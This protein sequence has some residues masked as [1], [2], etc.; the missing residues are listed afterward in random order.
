MI[1]ALILLAVC[2]AFG[3]FAGKTSNPMF[4]PRQAFN[5]FVPLFGAGFGAVVGLVYGLILV[6]FTAGLFH[7]VV[8]FALWGYVSTGAS[9]F[10]ARLFRR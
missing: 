8:P 7:V 5:I 3:F 4:S 10:V 1:A 9:L 6:G 2:F